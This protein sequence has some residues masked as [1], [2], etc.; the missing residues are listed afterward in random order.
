M[1][2]VKAFLGEML[3]GFGKH[4]FVVADA[5]FFLPAR[6]EE[7]RVQR[8]HTCDVGIRLG[9]DV[10]AAC[11]CAFHHGKTFQ[12]VVQAAA[13]D[14][15]DVQRRT[16]DGGRSNH[17]ADRLNG[18]ARLDLSGAAHVRV[19]RHPPLGSETEYFNHFQSRCS[20]CVLDSHPN[21]Q[22]AGVQ[23]RAQLLLHAFDLFRCSVL[24]GG[25]ATFWEDLR[26][27]GVNFFSTSR[28]R[29]AEDLSACSHMAGRRSV[30]DQRMAVLHFQKLGNVRH[31]DFQ[32]QCSG[33]T[34][35]RLDALA[36]QVLAVLVQIDEA[37]SD[38]EA[39]GGDNPLAAQGVGGDARDLST[40]DAYIADGVET[41][42]GIKNA[43]AF[44]DEVILLRERNRRPKDQQAIS[45]KAH[46]L[47]FS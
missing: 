27:A 5:K 16:R 7:R 40:V 19:N 25:G 1:K 43:T 14:V 41:A 37:R 33:D 3:A 21:G 22:S 13:V 44:D 11:A 31:A 34:V 17:F 46:K 26:D 35:K 45:Q 30:V 4:E 42:F 29:R 10:E 20:R 24:I 32:L 23:L 6:I 47:N 9:G 28:Q 12:R 2:F 38:D 39:A 15:H 18:R 8:R 36:F